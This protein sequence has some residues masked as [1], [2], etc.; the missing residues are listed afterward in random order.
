M[1]KALARLTFACVLAGCMDITMPNEFV[2]E[3]GTAR[4]SA[5]PPPEFPPEG[6]MCPDDTTQ[7]WYVGGDGICRVECVPVG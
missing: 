3:P 5:C 6:S 4:S 1:K 7:Y 2:L